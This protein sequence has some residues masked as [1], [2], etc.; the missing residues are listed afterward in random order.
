MT[1]YKRVYGLTGGIATGKSTVSEILR[2][3]GYEIIDMDK[4]ARSIFQIGKPAYRKVIEAF[5]RDIVDPLGNIDRKK[6]RA[7]VFSDDARLELLNRITHPEIM[8]E[9]RVLMEEI[10]GREDL[11]FL[12]IPL[13]FESREMLEAHGI[14]FDAVILVYLDGRTQLERLMARDQLDRQ[15]AR[16][17]I[18]YQMAMEDKLRL[19]DYVIDNSGDLNSLEKNV[20]KLLESIE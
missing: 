16:K 12:D 17:V 11:V 5:G 3:R 6:L 7:L 9:A 10:L 14:Y 18:N 20:D 15:E 13:L 2:A 8:L 1:H 4:L 19:A